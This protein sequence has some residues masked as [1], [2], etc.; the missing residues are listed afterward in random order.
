[1]WGWRLIRYLI[2]RACIHAPGCIRP[3]GCLHS[4]GRG[5]AIDTMRKIYSP[6]AR[7]N[8]AA[9]L[10]VFLWVG[11][12]SAYAEEPLEF[13]E[14]L[15]AIQVYL[16][17]RGGTYGSADFPRPLWGLSPRARRNPGDSITWL[18]SAGSI[19]ACAEEPQG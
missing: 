8:Q 15:S 19:S 12:I 4:P 14:C 7:R 1:M 9:V 13:R 3:G 18:A 2:E 16:R 17:V 5:V 11:S 10:G 6:P